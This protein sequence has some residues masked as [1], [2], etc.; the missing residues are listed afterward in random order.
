[1]RLRLPATRRR[2]YDIGDDRWSKG[3]TKAQH[4]RAEGRHPRAAEKHLLAAENRL[5]AA[6][7][8]LRAEGQHLGISHKRKVGGNRFAT[9]VGFPRPVNGDGEVWKR[10]KQECRLFMSLFIFYYYCVQD[11]HDDSVPGEV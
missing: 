6:E 3:F 8:H 4:F 9:A 7:Q 1:M 11:D 10:R 5:R 2:G